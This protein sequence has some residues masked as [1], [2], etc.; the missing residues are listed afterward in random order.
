MR[1]KSGRGGK[2]DGAGRPAG[3]GRPI[4]EESERRLHRGIR[5]PR[6]V[7][8]WCDAQDEPLARI[9]ERALIEHYKLRKR[10][11]NVRMRKVD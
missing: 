2:R 7:L 1:F 9:V 3:T 11:E 6:W 10:G 4:V 8:E 5:L